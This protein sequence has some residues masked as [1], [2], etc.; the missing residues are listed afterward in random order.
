MILGLQ[1]VNIP[2]FLRLASQIIVNPV[3]TRVSSQPNRLTSRRRHH[4][5]RQPNFA[6]NHG[7][8]IRHHRRAINRLPFT[9]LR[10]LSRHLSCQ[11]LNR[12]ITNHRTIFTKRHVIHTRNLHTTRVHNTPRIISYNSLPMLAMTITYRRLIRHF[13]KHRT[14]LRRHRHIQTRQQRNSILHQGH[15]SP[16]RRPQTAHTSNG[17]KEASNSTRLTNIKTTDNSK[18]NRNFTPFSN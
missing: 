10:H 7:H 5:V 17:T 12:R 1:T 2:R 4:Q 13:N 18:G 16:Q 9:V 6:T 8:D 14:L 3:S 15:T 11:A